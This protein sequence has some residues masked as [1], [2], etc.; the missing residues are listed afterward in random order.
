MLNKRI[1]EEITNLFNNKTD[2][3]IWFRCDDVG[4]ISDKFIRLNNLFIKH[5]AKSYYAVIPCA[6]QDQTL[7]EINKNKNVLIMQHGISH[8]N[9]SLDKEM[10]LIDNEVV[11]NE[12]IKNIDKLKNIFGYRYSGILCPPW[13]KVELGAEQKL[14][15]YYKGLSSYLNNKS[16]FLL[17]MNSNIDI[18]DWKTATYRGHEKILEKIK[19]VIDGNVIGFCIHH[20]QLNEDAFEFIEFIVSNFNKYIKF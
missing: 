2:L 13:N 7:N 1:K 14:S 11:I 6:L 4:I 9:N 18:T 3:K 19:N 15:K 20:N 12:C 5:N 10:E 16:G 17:D 8:K